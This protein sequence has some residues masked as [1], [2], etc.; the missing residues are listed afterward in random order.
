MDDGLLS[1]IS[2]GCGQ[3]VKMIITLEPHGTQITK[4]VHE[5]SNAFLR[6][7]Q[8]LLESLRKHV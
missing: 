7:V 2:T 8:N 4:K 1:I 3:L 6:S 5:R